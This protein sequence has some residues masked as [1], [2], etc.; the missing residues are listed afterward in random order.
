MIAKTSMLLASAS[1]AIG[2][3]G[4]PVRANEKA[5]A[6]VV[7]LGLLGIAAMAHHEDHY[8]PGQEP[9]TAEET[10]AF[11]RGYRDG[12]HNEPY[13]SLRSSAAYGS[14]Y[15]AGHKE[16]ANRLAHKHESHGDKVPNLASAGCVGEASA[17]W[18]RNPRDIHVVR[19]KKGGFSQAGGQEYQVEVAAGHKH[20]HCDVNDKGTVF[21]FHKGR[22]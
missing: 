17:Q 13:D 10:A 2:M 9:Q 15:D 18:G 21:K 4:T 3:A 6:A 7:A 16:R 22:L 5:A 11:E 1:L 19:A 8:R 20:G 14:G 12:L